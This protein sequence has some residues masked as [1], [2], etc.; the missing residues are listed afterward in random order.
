MEEAVSK[1]LFCE[2]A[3]TGA[4]ALS[5][6]EGE[7]LR[8]ELNGQLDVLR[9]LESIPLDE[10]LPPVI[11]GN[12]YPPHIRCE[13]RADEWNPFETPEFI[14]A[15]AP[16]VREGFIVSPEIITEEIGARD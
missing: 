3:K 9:Q 11:H 5:P 8:A 14:I 13:L 15:Q 7:E 6:D 1:T 16:L 2:L 10:S 4:L 12:P